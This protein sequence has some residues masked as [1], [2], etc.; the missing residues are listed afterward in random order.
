VRR[1]LP[2]AWLLVLVGCPSAPA[3]Y[4]ESEIVAIPSASAARSDVPA[5]AG[6]AARPKGAPSAVA[7][8]APDDDDDD[9]GQVGFGFGPP[10]PAPPPPPPTPGAGPF[11]RGAAAAGLAA[12]NVAACARRGGPGGPGHVRLTFAPSGFVVSAIVDSSP[13][14]G[15]AVAACV[16]QLFRQVRVPAFSGAPVTVGKAFTLP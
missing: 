11:D 9:D 13:V 4:V 8:D 2:L 6:S 10:T 16:E 1:P 15:T 5:P 7:L 3:K 12:V 14:A